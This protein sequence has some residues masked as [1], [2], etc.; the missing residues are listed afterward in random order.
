[1]VSFQDPRTIGR[2]Y[3]V[4]EP[5]FYFTPV[6]MLQ[7]HSCWQPK[8]QL[9][10]YR[11]CDSGLA[12]KWQTEFVGKSSRKKGKQGFRNLS[13][14]HANGFLYLILI[15]WAISTSSFATEV[16]IYYFPSIYKIARKR[17]HRA[18][19]VPQ[20]KKITFLN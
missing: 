18:K 16:L 2:I 10:F 19:I 11:L 6:V 8:F 13:M 7:K 17:S 12:R 14:A 5:I 4:D 9:I 15:G 1:M 3:Y 20:Q